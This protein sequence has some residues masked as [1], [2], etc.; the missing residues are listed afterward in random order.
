ME[1][2]AKL[3]LLTAAILVAMYVVGM[4]ITAFFHLYV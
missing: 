1:E 3:L 4:G 2:Q